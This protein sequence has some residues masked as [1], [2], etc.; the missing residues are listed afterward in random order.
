M[1]IPKQVVTSVLS[2]NNSFIRGS[3]TF[4]QISL[5]YEQ[6]VH[7]ALQ[8]TSKNVEE[9][10]LFRNSKEIPSFDFHWPARLPKLEV[11]LGLVYIESHEGVVWLAK[12][13]FVILR[14]REIRNGKIFRPT[15]S[16]RTIP[17]AMIKFERES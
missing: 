4:L 17:N 6:Q 13:V 2:R 7:D 15:K 16:T 8:D 14:T 10:I 12:D 11:Q 5:C 1:M 3:F 9:E